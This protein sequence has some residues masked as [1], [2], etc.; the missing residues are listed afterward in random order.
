MTAVFAL[1]VFSSIYFLYGSAKRELA[2]QEDQGVVIASSTLAP[3]ATF[4]QKVLYAKQVHQ[5]MKQYPE[6]DHVFQIN[7]PGGWSPEWC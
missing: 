1:L 4:Q 3:D 2:P 7:A 6:T 5:I